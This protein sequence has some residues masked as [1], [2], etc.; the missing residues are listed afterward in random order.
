[1]KEYTV[2]FESFEVKAKSYDEA[3]VIAKQQAWKLHEMKLDDELLQDDNQKPNCWTAVFNSLYIEA[4][5][6]DIA[7][8]NAITF[9]KQHNLDI[10]EIDDGH[11]N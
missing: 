6:K 7:W 9:A 2:D 3:W 10:I 11:E 1:L 8:M 5:N 4:P